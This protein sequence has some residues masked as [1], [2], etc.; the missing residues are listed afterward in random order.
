VN[1]WVL[2]A[3]IS[4]FSFGAAV[5]LYVGLRDLTGDFEYFVDAAW[6]LMLGQQPYIDFFLSFGLTLTALQALLFKAFG[7]EMYTL[8]VHAAVLNGFAAV[9]LFLLLRALRLHWGWAFVYALGT[10]LVFYPPYGIAMPVQH[11]AFFA[12]SILLVQVVALTRRTGDDLPIAALYFLAGV[13]AVAGYLSKPVPLGLFLPV[14][15]FLWLALPRRKIVIAVA[16]ALAGIV[17]SLFIIGL[18]IGFD[19]IVWSNLVQLTVETPLLIGSARHSNIPWNLRLYAWPSFYG[20]ASVPLTYALLAGSVVV[21]YRTVIRRGASSLDYLS[22]AALA[23]AANTLIANIEFFRVNGDWFW[24]GLPLLFLPLACFH[25]ALAG[26]FENAGPAAPQLRTVFGICLAGMAVLDSLYFTY[27]ALIMRGYPGQLRIVS[28]VADAAS[29]IPGLKHIRFYSW[30]AE[31]PATA[32][33]SSVSITEQDVRERLKGWQEIVT[34]LQR[35]G[36]AVEIIG[37]PAGVPLSFY[38]LAGVPPLLPVTTNSLPGYTAP[39]S[40]SVPYADLRNRIVKILSEQTLEAIV[41]GNIELALRPDLAEP[42]GSAM[43]G[44]ERRVQFTVFKPCG[45]LN[46]ATIEALLALRGMT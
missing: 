40:N 18:W 5:N 4:A 23:I 10:A 17:S 26:R 32:G 21:L 25:A 30:H 36:G 11:S 19:G 39:P 7:V 15:I 12:L 41:V 1:P 42:I 27:N 13:A 9:M 31:A 44:A 3:G 2:A 46:L 43:C 33:G 22:I 16:G 20:M 24:R 28:P 35:S 8:V 6:R 38:A 34:L 45:R 14:S 37:L 29:G